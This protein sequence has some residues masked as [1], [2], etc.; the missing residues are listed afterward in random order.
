MSYAVN[1]PLLNLSKHA[2]N[3]TLYY[4][5]GP[6]QARVSVNYRDKYLTAVPGRYNQDVQGT[7]STTFFD[8]STS[9][10]ITDKLT[11]SLEAL[12]LSNEKDISYIDSK[13]QRFENYRV[14]GR[15]FFMGVRYTY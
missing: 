9:Y 3:A 1:A 14:A 7:L 8:A 11:V 2:A 15:Q 12:N 4:E 13:A 6:L 5:R 10:R